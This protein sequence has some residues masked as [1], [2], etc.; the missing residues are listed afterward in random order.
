MIRRTLTFLMLVAGAVSSAAAQNSSG[1]GAQGDSHAFSFFFD[2]D[3]AYLGVQTADVT[4]E[5]FAKLGLREVRG[6]AVEKVVED[7]PAAAAGLQVGD[8]IVRLNG[9]AIESSR[10][11]TRLIS[12]VAPDHQVRI[13]VLRGGS[14]RE[15]TATLG[16]RPMPTFGEGGFR[17]R[18]PGQMGTLDLPRRPDADGSIDITPPPT[19]GQGDQQFPGFMWNSGNSRQIGVGVTALTK[20]LSDHFGVAGGLLINSV[21]ENS[22]A[23]K[24][25]L[26]AGDIITEADGRAVNGDFD[27]VRAIAEKKTGDIAL[28]IVRGGQ[29]QTVRV[30]P[31]EVKG[32]LFFRGPDGSMGFERMKLRTPDLGSFNLNFPTDA[33][34]FPSRVY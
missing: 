10:K 3:G 32:D 27:L 22:P 15:L 5:N 12:E 1:P 7:S 17:V 24:A 30:T 16:K 13:T 8:V 2:G 14:E 20:Q 29:K 33:F 11:L 19:P 34:K 21:R 26:K 18:V 28:T 25:G 4:R 9:E 6:V 31:E 23:A